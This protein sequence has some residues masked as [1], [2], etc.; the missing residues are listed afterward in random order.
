MKTGWNVKGA[1]KHASLSM[2]ERK[3][4]FDFASL[5]FPQDPVTPSTVYFGQGGDKKF[6]DWDP[7]HAHIAQR[8]FEGGRG[9]YDYDQDETSFFDSLMCNTMI[10]GRVVPMPQFRF[11]EGY[12]NAENFLPGGK[13]S[14]VGDDM[15][16]YPLYNQYKLARKFTASA[17]YT[18]ARAFAWFRQV[19]EPTSNLTFALYSDSG[20]DPNALLDSETFSSSDS[21]DSFLSFLYEFQSDISQAITD[22][23]DYWAV[24]YSDANDD[25]HNHWEV[26]IGS[27]ASD[28]G[29]VHDTSSWGNTDDQLY[30]RVTTAVFPG[31]WIPFVLEGAQYVVDNQRD[32]TAASLYINGDRGIATSGASTTITDS[33]KSWTLDLFIGA[34]V[35]VTKGTGKGQYRE[36]TDNSGSALTVS[37]AWD[38]TPDGTSEYVIYAT[39]ELTPITLTGDAIDKPVKDVTIYDDQAVLCFGPDQ[40]I[41][42]IRWNSGG[43]QHDGRDESG[44]AKAD[45]LRSFYNSNSGKTVIWRAENDTVDVSF[46]E[47]K[48]WSTDLDFGEEIPVG[49]DSWGINSLLDHNNQLWIFKED[50]VW[51]EQNNKVVKVNLG[52]DSMAE[53]SNGVAVASWKLFIYANWSHSIEQI[54]SGNVLDMGPW[55]HAGLPDGRTGVVS[56][57][58]PV[59][60]FMFAGIDGEVSNTSSVLAWNER[61]YHEVFRAWTSNRRIEGLKWQACPGT[62]PRLWMSVGGDLVIQ[63]WPK[64]TLNPLNDSTFKY[65]HECYVTQGIIDMS[66]SNINKLFRELTIASKN[67][68]EGIEIIPQYQVD[69]DIAGGTWETIHHYTE[70]PHEEWFIGEGNRKRIQVRIVMRTKDADIPPV[71]L[72]PVLEGFAR[73]PTKYQWVVQI[74]TKSISLGQRG[75]RNSDADEFVRFLESSSQAAQEL[76]LGCRFRRMD[77]L[78][79]IVEPPR[80]IRQTVD[81]SNF[82][83][84][85][86]IELAIREA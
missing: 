37:P 8:S 29:K 27:G 78:R 67:L 71:L 79:V 57:L 43:P 86:I 40:A 76:L 21:Y 59:H 36:I 52:L 14:A 13:R 19:G 68:T 53:G 20:G 11:A 69:T 51:Y 10:P 15:G 33:T 23:T 63:E 17:S 41:L 77:G 6:G 66:T 26:G 22:G 58:Q 1:D 60:A 25:E 2:G 56:A 5:S 35:R 42:R 62:R 7:Q 48:A 47:N 61:G 4:Y 34:W 55:L 81:E 18:V 73:V 24:V 64:F 9:R 70:S 12:V 32:G 54:Y 84:S 38:V 30:F 44:A 85:G 16:W 28:Q 65:H 39:D 74:P 31:R 50:S 82:S 80:V 3:W 75:F 49:E 83:W 45:A 72:A 46:S